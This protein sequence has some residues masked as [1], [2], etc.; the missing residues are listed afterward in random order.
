MKED[1][2]EKRKEVAEE[3]KATLAELENGEELSS[4]IGGH[5]LMSRLFEFQWNEPTLDIDFRMP[6]AL[7]LADEESQKAANADIGAAIRMA[8]LLLMVDSLKDDGSLDELSL[9]VW[10]DENGIGYSISDGEGNTV[11]SDDDWTGLI[12]RLETVLPEGGESLSIIWP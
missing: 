3:L 11:E 9:T 4:F 2:D 12:R 5:G 8:L 6:Y 10:A 7:V 1:I